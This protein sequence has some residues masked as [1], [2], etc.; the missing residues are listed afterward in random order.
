MGPLGAVRAMRRTLV[1]VG[2]A[3]AALLWGQSV[4][5]LVANPG[6]CGPAEASL[7]VGGWGLSLV[8]VH[9][10]A[11]RAAHRPVHLPVHR[12]GGQPADR[13]NAGGATSGGTSPGWQRGHQ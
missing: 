3:V 1:L 4:W 5:Q 7:A 13:G 2:G 10:V 12:G 6:G 8:P 9:V 11:H